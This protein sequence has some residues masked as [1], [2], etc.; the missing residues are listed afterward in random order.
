RWPWLEPRRL[1]DEAHER[2]AR[3][4]DDQSAGSRERQAGGAAEP[5]VARGAVVETRSRPRERARRLVSGGF[6]DAPPLIADHDITTATD[7]DPNGAEQPFE[8]HGVRGD[9]TVRGDGA[10]HTASGV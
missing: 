8:R 9:E 5:R 6:H 7:G 3:V 1:G 10:D 2:I 4:G